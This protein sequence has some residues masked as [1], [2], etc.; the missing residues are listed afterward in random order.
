M[1]LKKSIVVPIPVVGAPVAPAA[2][3]VSVPAS[4]G[5]WKND[6]GTVDLTLGQT[7]THAA[8]AAAAATNRLA[9]HLHRI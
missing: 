6:F 1:S 2:P 4:T 9:T 7:T 8:A 3:T 5:V